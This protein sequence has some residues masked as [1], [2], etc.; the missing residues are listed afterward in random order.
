MQCKC[1]TGKC[2]ERYVF[3][4]KQ[5]C[6]GESRRDGEYA[7]VHA[8]NQWDEVKIFSDT[9]RCVTNQ[10]ICHLLEFVSLPPSPSEF[11][12]TSQ[13]LTSP[14]IRSAAFGTVNH[15]LGM[16][17]KIATERATDTRQSLNDGVDMIVNV[18]MLENNKEYWLFIRN[19]K[20]YTFFLSTCL[21]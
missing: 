10:F 2:T 8:V 15:L 6:V 13:S 3:K 7:Q 16:Q 12:Q 14:L 18:C 19:Q 9:A 5:S 1:T 21:F 20:D 11:V 4:V 17:G